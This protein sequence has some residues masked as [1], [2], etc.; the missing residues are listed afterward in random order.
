MRLAFPQDL[1]LRLLVA[2]TAQQREQPVPQ[3]QVGRMLATLTALPVQLTELMQLQLTKTHIIEKLTL[4][5]Q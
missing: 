4:P 3:A 2:P 1:I 5:G